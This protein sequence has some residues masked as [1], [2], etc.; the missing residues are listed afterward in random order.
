MSEKSI[1]ARSRK[2]ANGV[3]EVFLKLGPGESCV[4]QTS[5]AVIKGKA[6]PYFSASGKPEIVAG[7]W[8]IKFRD[9]GPKL[10][11]SV[12]TTQL[13]SWTEFPGDDVKSFQVLR[14]IVLL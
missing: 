4:L 14:S 13:G 9:G 7:E 6:F 8:A 2:S 1:V 10:P 12:R 5:A 11:A 3:M